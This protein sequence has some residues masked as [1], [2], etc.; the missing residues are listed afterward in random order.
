[1]G[2]HCRSPGT[3]APSVS[4]KEANAGPSLER[5]RSIFGPPRW[6]LNFSQRRESGT[7]AE[8]THISFSKS[9][10]PFPHI[11]HTV[12]TCLHSTHCSLDRAHTPHTVANQR[13]LGSANPSLKLHEPELL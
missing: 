7:L 4:G 9:K 1:M 8:S 13:V 5:R 11:S 3:S 12:A 2:A 10:R 6:Q